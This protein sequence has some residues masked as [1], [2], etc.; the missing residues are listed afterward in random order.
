MQRSHRGVTLWRIKGR[1][2]GRQGELWTTM[3]ILPPRKETRKEGVVSDCSAIPRMVWPGWQGVFEPEVTCGKSC[4]SGRNG[5]EFVAPQWSGLEWD[6]PAGS[7]SPTRTWQWI[8]RG[9]IWG[10]QSTMPPVVG[11]VSS[12][13]PWLPQRLLQFLASWRWTE[14]SWSKG[15][16]LRTLKLTGS[17]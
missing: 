12:W 1:D 17:L 4:K 2:R 3:E 15:Q 9:G 14:P 13:F 8:Q 7:V 10:C 6:Q 11:D 16:V 5:L